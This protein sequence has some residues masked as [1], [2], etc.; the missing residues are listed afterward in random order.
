MAGVHSHEHEPFSYKHAS[1]LLNP[2]RRL[3]LSPKKLA[4]RLEL[5]R[6]SKVLELGP[7]PGYFSLEVARRIPEGILVLVDIQQEMLDMAK[8]RFE[9]KGASN[10]RYLMGKADSLH[11]A[12]GPYDVVFL[13]SVLGE[14]PDKCGCLR[15][16]HGVLRPGGLLSVT[17]IRH[18]PHFLPMPEVERLAREEGFHFE[19]SF[20]RSRNYTANFRKSA[21]CEPA[22][23]HGR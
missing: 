11:A 10:V 17:E 14:V 6:D 15:E 4:G 23:S 1:H 12:G 5:R 3:F 13:A 21:D 8:E 9:K 19:K 22:I 2:L 20:G 18:D 16:I 7:G